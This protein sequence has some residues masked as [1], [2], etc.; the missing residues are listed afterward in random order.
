MMSSILV[1]A[2]AVNPVESA[3]NNCIM[4]IVSWAG[5]GDRSVDLDR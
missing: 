3:V 2:K 4:V 5:A 1:A